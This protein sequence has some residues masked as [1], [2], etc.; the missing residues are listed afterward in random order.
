MIAKFL[1][2]ADLHINAQATLA[3]Q[4]RV[5][6]NGINLRTADLLRAIGAVAAEASRDGDLFGAVIAGDLYDHDRPTP[7]EEEIAATIIETLSGACAGCST[8]VLVIDGNHDI[9]RGTGPSAPTSLNWHPLAMMIH[10]PEVVC[11]YGLRIGCLPYPRIGGNAELLRAGAVDA[12][13]AGL[14]AGGADVLVAHANTGQAVAG[15]QPRP[16]DDAVTLSH[17]VL[18][19]F[20]C[21]MLGHIH[22][23]QE[24]GPVAYCGSPMVEDWG[25]A[26]DGTVRGAAL[27]T[28]ECDADLASSPPD[29]TVRSATLRRLS[30]PDRT[31]IDIPADQWC[32]DSVDPSSGA[33]HRVKGRLR[34]TD[35]AA[36]HAEIRSLRAK[37]A[38]IQ[39]EITIEQEDRRRSE[40]VARALTDDQILLGAIKLR[41][42]DPAI[43]DGAMAVVQDILGGGA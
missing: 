36:V 3:G 15:K 33:V 27:W 4:V 37:G 21:V 25:E 23:P 41:Q 28:L 38:L 12:I 26:N 34:A 39:A 22:R 31:W 9:P 18:A 14:R 10:D 13:A 43:V 42:T 17:A 35:A 5:G 20:P 8:K 11:Y 1:H 29:Y 32:E 30:A 40:D 6:P 16:L 2:L 7:L 19:Q 24:W